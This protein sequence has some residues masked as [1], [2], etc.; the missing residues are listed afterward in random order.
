MPSVIPT[1]V[2]A[3]AIVD[4]ELLGRV[5]RGRRYRSVGWLGVLGSIVAFAV[6]QLNSVFGDESVSSQATTHPT[7]FAIGGIVL[8]I[9]LLLVNWTRI[10]VQ[11]SREP[12]Q[13]TFSVGAFESFPPGEGPAEPLAPGGPMDWLGRDLTE[14]LSSRVQRLSLLDE[15]DAPKAEPDG[16]PASHVHITGWYG[17]RRLEDGNWVLEVVPKVRL[18]GKGAAAKLAQTVCFRLRDGSSGNGQPG[19]QPPPLDETA[20]RRLFERVY[21]SVAST[22][23]DQIRRG[24]EEKVGL[25]PP[26]HLRAAAYLYEADDY[27]ASN[28]LDAYE[29]A[30][31]LYLRALEMYDV[32]SR[33]RPAT[34]WR[35]TVRGLRRGLDW[36]RRRLRLIAAHALRYFGRREVLT[37]RARL[38]YAR[39][40]AAEWHLRLLCGTPPTELYEAL[41]RIAKTIERLSRVP[42]DVPEQRQ[43]LFRAHVADAIVKC[44][45]EDSP[46]AAVA[47]EEAEAELP[48]G[49][50]E[51]PEFLFAAGM[52]E[53]EPLRSLRLFGQ[54][55]E[56]DPALERAHY[57]RALESESLWRRRE[58]LEPAIAHT[59]DAEYSTVI[60]I[61]PGNISAWANRGYIGWLLSP[62]IS[63]QEN[64]KADGGFDWRTHAIAMLEAGTQYKEVRRETMIAELDWTLTRLAAEEGRFA[65]AYE[66]YI[67]A[68]SAMLDEPRVKFL[69]QFYRVITPAVVARYDRYRSEVERHAATAKGEGEERMVQSVLA[70][71]H[72]DCALAYQAHWERSGNRSELR[73]AH[74]AFRAAIEANPHFVLPKLYLAE[75]FWNEAN[76]ASRRGD[77]EEADGLEAEVVRLLAD[78]V[79]REPECL[80]AQLLTVEVKA[81]QSVRFNTMRNGSQP[82][83]FEHEQ[84]AC[85][86]K[87]EEVLRQLLPHPAFATKDGG[88]R[89]AANG[90]YVRELLGDGQ[91][92]WTREFTE[93]HVRALVQWVNAMAPLAPDQAD[94]LCE[95]LRGVYHRCRPELLNAHVGVAREMSSVLNTEAVQGRGEKLG[96]QCLGL[97]GEIVDSILKDDP[98]HHSVLEVANLIDEDRR[99]EILLEAAAL[100]SSPATLLLVAEQ[101]ISV[102]E[103][104]E[105]ARAFWRAQRLDGDAMASEH[106]LTLGRLEAERERRSRAVRAFRAAIEAGNGV[107]AAAMAAAESAAL[108]AQTQGQE[109]AW[110][111][112]QRA[113][114]RDAEIALVLADRLSA[115]ERQEEAVAVYRDLLAG[116]TAQS[117]AQRAL[118][119][120]A[121]AALLSTMPGDTSAEEKRLLAEAAGSQ[122]APMRSQAAVL[123]AGLLGP[124]DPEKAKL[125]DLQALEDGDP[126]VVSLA[127]GRL[128]LNLRVAGKE[129]EA[130]ELLRKHASSHSSVAVQLGD[131]L[132]GGGLYREAAEMYALGAD[133]S[134]PEPAYAVE[135]LLHHGDLLAERDEGKA[136]EA[137]YWRA[138]EARDFQRSP[139]AVLAMQRL[140]APETFQARERLYRSVMK[141]VDKP[142]VAGFA[143]QLGQL[144]EGAG[145]SAAAKAVYQAARERAPEIAVR[146]S[147]LPFG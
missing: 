55:V 9:S 20:Y 146:D 82:G 14:K 7:Q 99:R 113:V 98:V 92:R 71:V 129:A 121:L 72:N 86:S 139:E 73:R 26:G 91:V 107:E 43:V 46:G 29:A 47:L 67:A 81:K 103:P 35:R 22:I 40:L 65:A 143:F 15:E 90:R 61:N 131:T 38:G 34:R 132:R 126:Q 12:F 95:R 122:T 6:T 114:A 88:T 50:R 97:L 127:A 75:L 116:D 135:A 142:T 49:A 53:A 39:T 5:R 45:L 106:Y 69:E 2:P 125:F 41:P 117:E 11:E 85:E 87:L 130:D 58:E 144:L 123:L 59:V 30:R 74:D 105:A 80:P 25:L 133:P 124:E 1:K 136:A 96:Q 84:R 37:A 76:N 16:P 44:L 64:G 147:R 32:G 51:K 3:S 145:D 128:A 31:T 115:M 112:L 23:Y 33:E 52:I 18:G 13:Y 77:V 111:E 79:R 78:V 70:F 21:W 119:Q 104:N 36:I 89:L 109:A 134:G 108:L 100:T 54:A 83:S 141:R 19:A 10:W 4:P 101:L 28:T 57:H 63:E 118:G 110:E 66:H 140:R 93:T 94:L 56:L 102:G 120:V 138:V 48:A 60:S 68:V 62:P 27:A 42:R 137:L 17:I 24:V 8:T